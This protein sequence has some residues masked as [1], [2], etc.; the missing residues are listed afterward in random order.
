VRAARRRAGAASRALASDRAAEQGQ[1]GE[2]EDRAEGHRK[3]L[4]SWYMGE[5]GP[6]EPAK[7]ACQRL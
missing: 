4:G 3:P 7:S 2:E 1:T 6:R 5:T